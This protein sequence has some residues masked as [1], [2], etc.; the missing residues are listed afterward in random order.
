[1]KI[2]IFGANGFIG[3]VMSDYFTEKEHQVVAIARRRA[4]CSLSAKFV[5]WDGLKI[6]DWKDELEGADVVI[7]LAGRTVNCRY[8]QRNRDEIMK[9]RTLTTSLIGKAIQDLT[10]PPEV[11]L[12]SSTATI[13]EHRE[14]AEGSYP[15]TEE[16]GV[17]GDDFS[18]GVAKAWERAFYDDKAKI[19]KVALRTAIVLGAEKETVFD[20][21]SGIVRIG[22]GGKMGSGRQMISWIHEEDVCRAIE[23]LIENRNAK[24]NYNLSAP[25]AEKNVNFMR[26][27]RQ[28]WKVACGLP[29]ARWMLAIGTFI[30]RTEGELVLKS[31]WVYPQR[32]LDEGFT[33]TYPKLPEAL[34]E[35]RGRFITKQK[36]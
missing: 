9:S 11:W 18:M 7:N 35:L 2:I 12:N 34:I 16:E 36:K 8:N 13:Y 28:T 21:L 33:F 6:G 5:S 17:I 30:M 4:G 10:S 22:L 15:H 25:N 27:L 14:Q 32:L 31:R 26:I 20:K 23:F 3:R 1:M 29:A 24:G 19:R